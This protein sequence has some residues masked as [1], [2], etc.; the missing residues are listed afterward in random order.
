MNRAFFVAGTDTDIGKSVVCAWLLR[1]LDADYWKPVQSG[2]DWI[3]GQPFGDSERVQAL[4]DW[5]AERFHPPTYT[6]NQPLSPHASA[7]LDGVEIELSRF[8]LPETDRTLVVE[9]AGGLL[10]PLNAHDLLIDLM[11]QLGLPVILVARSGLGTINHSLLSLDGMR[12]RGLHCA[13]VVMV[14]EPSPS[15]KQAI[16]HYGGVSVL[17]EIPPL[18]P[19]NSEALDRLPNLPL[20]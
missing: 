5:P 14:G 13:G 15:N 11:A 19:L 8:A 1:Q 9:G 16:E 2:L 7:A 18:D 3:D 10:V 4:A 20:L 12:A 17:A 6:L